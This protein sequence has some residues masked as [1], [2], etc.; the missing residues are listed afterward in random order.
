MIV[1]SVMVLF[2]EL[3]AMAGAK[4]IFLCTYIRTST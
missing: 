4:S 3:K 2:F 1:L